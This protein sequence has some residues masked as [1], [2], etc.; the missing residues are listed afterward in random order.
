VIS[1]VRC[2]CIRKCATKRRNAEFRNALQGV[3]PHSPVCW[4]ARP[5]RA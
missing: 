4:L 2:G 1:V 5:R 3:A